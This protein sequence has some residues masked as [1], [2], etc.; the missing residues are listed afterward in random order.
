M[1]CTIARFLGM[2]DGGGGSLGRGVLYFVCLVGYLHDGLGG[3]S[4]TFCVCCEFVVFVCYHGG[5]VPVC[6]MDVG[7]MGKEGRHDMGWGGCGIVES[8]GDGCGVAR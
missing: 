2:R 7:C 4:D 3:P 1:E 8:R 6:G 5:F